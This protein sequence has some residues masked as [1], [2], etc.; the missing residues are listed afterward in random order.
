MNHLACVLLFVVTLIAAA[1]AQEMMAPMPEPELEP[2]ME[3]GSGGM[4]IVPE[5]ALSERCQLSQD[6]C[7][8]ICDRVRGQMDFDC[9][10]QG[11]AFSSSCACGST[12]GS[13]VSASARSSILGRGRGL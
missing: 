6:R 12:S 5:E 7:Q 3:M 2:E 4:A 1:A 9:D 13:S 11:G 8:Q 10:D